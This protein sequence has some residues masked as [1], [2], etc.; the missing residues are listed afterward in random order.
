MA[1]RGATRAA[2][3]RGPDDAGGGPYRRAV[4]PA[5]PVGAPEWGRR[6]R[7]KVGGRVEGVE[8]A[9]VESAVL[10]KAGLVSST[11]PRPAFVARRV[12]RTGPGLPGAV[13]MP[14]AVA[15]P[16]FDAGP[17]VLARRFASCEGIASTAEGTFYLESACRT[18]SFLGVPPDRPPIIPAQFANGPGITRWRPGPRPRDPPLRQALPRGARNEAGAILRPGLVDVC[19]AP[20]RSG[21]AQSSVLISRSLNRTSI[22]GPTWTCSA[23]MPD[24]ANSGSLRSVTVVPFNSMMT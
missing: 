16:H 10:P 1:Q 22:A 6:R 15:R 7:K 9:G 17:T 2:P 14:A 12:M 24:F 20:T 21:S 13:R 18:R 23:M 11:A 5:G 19:L 8:R 3:K 4:R